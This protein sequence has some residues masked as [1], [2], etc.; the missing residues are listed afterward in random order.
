MRRKEPTRVLYREQWV[1]AGREE[2]FQ[3]FSD[4]HNL[5]RITPSFLH[6]K[7]KTPDPI[8]I[9]QGTELEYRLTLHRV[10]LIWKSLIAEWNPPYFFRDDQVHGPFR[11]WSHEHIFKRLGNGTLII[12]K[13]QFLIPG[14]VFEPLI[15]K[16]FVSKDL[17][18]IFDYRAL[19]VKKLWGF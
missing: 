5:E 16:V 8:S 11:F 6:F 1:P 13:V 4:P 10:G 19:V 17:E 9:F 15:N 3:F 7:I 14:G 12:D 2:I 18:R